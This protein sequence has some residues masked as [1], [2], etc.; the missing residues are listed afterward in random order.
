MGRVGLVEGTRELLQ[1]PF[2][3]VYEVDEMN[4]A[5]VVIAIMRGAEDRVYL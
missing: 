1:S 4:N 5:I 2:V 3:T